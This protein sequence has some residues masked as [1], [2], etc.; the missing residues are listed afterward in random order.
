M[1][2]TIQK[3]TQMNRSYKLL[4]AK[5]VV[6]HETATP[7][8]TAENEYR[9]FNTNNVSASAHA[10][11]DWNETIQTVPWNEMAWHSKEPANSMFI[12]IEMCRPAHHDPDK[13]NIVYNETVALFSRLFYLILKINKVTSS[14]LMSHDEVRLKWH[15]TTHTD[16]TDYL[17]EYGKD[18]NM[19]RRD[20]QAAIN[21]LRG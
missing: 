7:G 15:R 8:A 4:N 12:G 11:V 16:P 20:V 19:F 21:K 17:R 14:N 2:Q 13:F 1:R 6:L 18:I 5:G 10:F 3:F 9:Y